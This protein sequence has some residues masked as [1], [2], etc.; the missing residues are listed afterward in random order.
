[1]KGDS[2][3]AT[4]VAVTLL[5]MQL[6]RKRLGWQRLADVQ[7]PHGTLT[8]LL[9]GGLLRMRRSERATKELRD[10]GAELGTLIGDRWREGDEREARLI[11]LQASVERM[12]RWLV[13]VTVAVGLI[14]IAGIGATL[15]AA[16]H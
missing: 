16:L 15:W 2:A 14:G 10:I 7:V 3:V 5:G 13:L 9:L 11:E 1:M 8:A 12:T 4:G 6:D